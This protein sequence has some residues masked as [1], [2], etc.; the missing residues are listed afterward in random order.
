MSGLSCA[1]VVVV[2]RLVA[3][4]GD[5]LEEDVLDAGVVLAARRL[6]LPVE[7]EQAEQ[8]IVDAG[9]GGLC[10]L[11]R[12]LARVLAAALVGR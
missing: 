5:E 10:A 2:L 11:G 9:F 8:R 6:R 4:H 3:G 1:I 7:L 12:L